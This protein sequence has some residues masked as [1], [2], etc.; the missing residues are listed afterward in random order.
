MYPL[1]SR[2]QLGGLGQGVG[3]DLSSAPTAAMGWKAYWSAWDSVAYS[4]AG[5][6][7]CVANDP[8][9]R[10]S[11]TLGV[12]ANAY[13][14]QT[15]LGNRPLYKTG[16]ANGQPYWLF[17]G[18]NDFLASL[19]A[20]NFLAA[21]AKV[22]TLACSIAPDSNNITALGDT[23]SQYQAIAIYTGRVI[24]YYNYSGAAQYSTGQSY[25]NSV[26]FVFTVKHV[27]G[28]LYDRKNGG[29]WSAAVASG[30]TGALTRLFGIGTNG[31]TYLPFS[32][33]GA[34]A[35]NTVSDDNITLVENYFK[36]KLG[37]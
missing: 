23:T 25:S 31:S 2:R 1:A 8:I 29:A 9:Y 14:E 22:I 4:D 21:G 35:A 32:F 20:S 15:T 11:E 5:T 36:Q 10:G 30:N 7:P 37:I 34:A 6:T 33:Y 28:N 13:M 16:G 27:G 12:V 26:P 17:D 19:A 3:G 18:S 24:K